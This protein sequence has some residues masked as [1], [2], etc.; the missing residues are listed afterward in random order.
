MA[1]KT[2]EK[3]GRLPRSTVVA[4]NKHEIYKNTSK[5]DRKA[6]V[7]AQTNDRSKQV[8]LPQNFLCVAI[9]F[10]VR[11]KL[12][13]FPVFSLSGKVNIRIPCFPCALNNS[14]THCSLKSLNLHEGDQW[15]M[16]DFQLGGIDPLGARRPLMWVLFGE[17][18]C[19][20]ERIGS[21]KG[22]A[23]QGGGVLQHGITCH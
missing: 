8:L 11:I 19:E 15:P 10:R 17:N 1:V 3:C 22:R 2:C 14:S 21:C 12:T 9:I 5:S 7:A 18:V 23:R 4:V 6:R 20:N 16:Q 13:K